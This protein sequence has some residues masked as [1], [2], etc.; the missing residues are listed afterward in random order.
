MH[1]TADPAGLT[2]AATPAAVPATLDSES[3]SC[4][5]VG[6]PTLVYASIPLRADFDK[7]ALPA[8]DLGLRM[9]LNMQV[10]PMRD[11]PCRLLVK[12]LEQGDFTV[13]FQHWGRVPETDPELPAFLAAQP[14]AE[15]A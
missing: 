5:W 11:E 6:T 10:T 15:V 3:P 2:P 1:P 7:I 4:A 12:S 8:R 9:R 14:Q 13:I